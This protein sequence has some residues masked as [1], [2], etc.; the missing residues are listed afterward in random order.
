VSGIQQQAVDPPRV[1]ADQ[2][3]TVKDGQRT[4]VM[5]V[6]LGAEPSGLEHEQRQDVSGQTDD[7][8]ERGSQLQQPPAPRPGVF[9][10]QRCVFSVCIKPE[11]PSNSRPFID[12]HARQ[13][14]IVRNTLATVEAYNILFAQQRCFE[15]ITLSTRHGPDSIFELA[16]R[17]SVRLKFRHDAVWSPGIEWNTQ[18]HLHGLY[19]VRTINKF[20]CERGGRKLAHF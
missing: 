6:G 10:T 20:V 4:Q 17:S 18:R 15:N 19:S 7:D 16:R 14:T 1:L 9:G 8:D 11:E 5:R 2:N 13:H 12:N 3:E